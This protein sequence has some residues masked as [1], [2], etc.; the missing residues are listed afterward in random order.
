MR[1]KTTYTASAE[2]HAREKREKRIPSAPSR[3]FTTFPQSKNTSRIKCRHAF[4]AKKISSKTRARTCI[5]EPIAMTPIMP[6]ITIT[7]DMEIEATRHPDAET[8]VAEA[9]DAEGQAAVIRAETGQA[10]AVTRA[11]GNLSLTA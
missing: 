1:Q 11:T 9:M 10:P 4:P 2:R 8:A 5:S 6:T 7:A 3:M